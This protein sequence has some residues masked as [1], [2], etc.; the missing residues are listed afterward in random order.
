MMKVAVVGLGWWGKEIIR[1]ISRSPRFTVVYGVDPMPPP[2]IEAFAE[3]FKFVL[4]SDL[5]RVLKDVDVE[6]V[7]LATPHALHE[8]QV[9][10]VVAAGKNVFCEKPLT[11]T[12]AGAERVLDACNKVGAIL[13]IG[14]ERRYEPAFEELGRLIH[15]G[16]L[17]RLLHIEANVS[18]D[19][20]RKLDTKNWRLSKSNAPAAMMT[21]VGIHIT[22]LFV[23]YAGA[24]AEV[25][26]QTASLVFEP[27]AEDFVV[28]NITFKS[29]VRATLTCLS[30]TPFYGRITVFGDAGWVEIASEGNVDQGKPTILTHCAHMGGE[31]K[32]IIYNPVNAVM[33]NFNAWAAAVAGETTYRFTAEQLLENIRLLEAIAVSAE[34][35]GQIVRL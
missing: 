28:A 11:L 19:L 29:G 14:H 27:P 3:E 2:G 9:L 35:D 33:L 34:K 30:S 20:F 31:R 5:E 32:Q 16:A 23:S 18:H 26:A 7:I 6:G 24:V 21:A 25:R 22:D 10:A 1:C 17:G 8:R 15:S 12:G 13:G 4:E